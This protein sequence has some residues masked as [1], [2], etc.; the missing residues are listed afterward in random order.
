[1]QGE[2]KMNRSDMNGEQII[3]QRPTSRCQQRRKIV[4]RADEKIWIMLG[5]I[6]KTDL[7]PRETAAGHCADRE[8]GTPKNSS[9]PNAFARQLVSEN[10]KKTGSSNN[11]NRDPS[12]RSWQKPW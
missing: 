11:N 8:R 10:G 6:E 9:D 3:F 1:M 7:K 12:L 5:A 4:T 2:M